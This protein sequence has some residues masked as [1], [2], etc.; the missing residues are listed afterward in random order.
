[1]KNFLLSRKNILQLVL[2]LS[3]TGLAL[4]FTHRI[5]IK[6]RFYYGPSKAAEVY[7]RT[8]YDFSCLKQKGCINKDDKESDK[9]SCYVSCRKSNPIPPEKSS[10]GV[11]DIIDRNFFAQKEYE[12]MKKFLD[13]YAHTNYGQWRQEAIKDTNNIDSNYFRTVCNVASVA[14]LYGIVEGKDPSYFVEY[15]DRIMA[16]FDDYKYWGN[17]D[18]QGFWAAP[19]PGYNCAIAASLMWDKFST[20]TAWDKY[21]GNTGRTPSQKRTQIRSTLIDLAEKI[22]RKYNTDKLKALHA[23]TIKEGNTQAEEAAWNAAYLALVS[24]L[25]PNSGGKYLEEA[26]KLSEF[27][28]SHCSNETACVLDENFLA[29]NHGVKPHPLYGISVIMFN[30]RGGLPFFVFGAHNRDAIPREL[31]MLSR[32]VY[33]LVNTFEANFEYA[34]FYDMSLMGRIT[35]NQHLQGILK[36]RYED[37]TY[38][39]IRGVCEWGMGADYNISPFAYLHVNDKYNSN[40]YQSVNGPYFYFILSQDRKLNSG[41]LYLPPVIEGGKTSYKTL[42]WARQAPIGLMLNPSVSEDTRINTHFFLN[43]MKAFEHLVSYLYLNNHNYLHK[44]E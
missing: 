43:S 37:N 24:Q 44:F 4:Y 20:N 40:G 38:L 32:S 13:Y 42:H 41:K 27:S 30:A 12:Y 11:G 7:S 6:K 3:L 21:S 1:M 10:Y 33:N 23:T 29:K 19:I 35:E 5:K 2:L 14:T 31:R 17:S 28:V 22:E 36:N 26:K 34:N 18:N 9:W 16:V 8:V 39:G 15:E 25:L